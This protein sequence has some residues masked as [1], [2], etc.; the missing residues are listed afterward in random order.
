M[1]SRHMMVEF[2]PPLVAECF[3]DLEAASSTGGW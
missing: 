3:A 1:A 2:E